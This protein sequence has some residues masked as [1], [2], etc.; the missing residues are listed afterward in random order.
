[1]SDS[2][3]DSTLDDL[4]SLSDSS[5]RSHAAAVIARAKR[6]LEELRTD[7]TVAPATVREYGKSVQQAE[8]RTGVSVTDG[9][10][11]RTKEN[12]DLGTFARDYDGTPDD[13]LEAYLN[14]PK[15]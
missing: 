13:A 14:L 1:M 15:K 10:T 4:Q 11:L 7:D 5:N 6:K 2:P 9:G 12:T 8:R 3:I